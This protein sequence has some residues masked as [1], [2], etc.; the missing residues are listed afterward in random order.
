MYHIQ[1]D[2]YQIPDGG[3]RT[4]ND[5]FTRASL[6]TCRLFPTDASSLGSPVDGCIEVFQNIASTQDFCV[7]GYHANLEKLF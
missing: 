3:F 6:P 7:K 1:L 5:F 2:T 4:V